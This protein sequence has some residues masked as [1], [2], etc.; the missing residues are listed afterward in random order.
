MTTHFKQEKPDKKELAQSVHVSPS[1]A[2]TIRTEATTS[3][4]ASD[5]NV[6]QP[7]MMKQSRSVHVSAVSIAS[8][9]QIT[10]LESTSAAPVKELVCE[11]TSTVKSEMSALIVGDQLMPQVEGEEMKKGEEKPEKASTT[12]HIEPSSLVI[13]SQQVVN[14]TSTSQTQV[15]VSIEREATKVAEY[16]QVV[17]ESATSPRKVAR[18]EIAPKLVH[19]LPVGEASVSEM[20]S[21]LHSHKPRS[22]RSYLSVQCSPRRVMSVEQVKPSESTSDIPVMNL[23][24]ETTEK[25]IP[26]NT[27]IQVGDQMIPVAKEIQM[28]IIGHEVQHASSIQQIDT[29]NV[30]ISR[31]QTTRIPSLP[32]S[33]IA[34]KLVHVRPVGEASVSEIATRL[35]EQKPDCKRSSRSIHYSPTR[36][37]SVERVI[38][39]ESASDT[40]ALNVA[41]ETAIP[42]L[43]ENTATQVGDLLIPESKEMQINIEEVGAE[44]TSSIHQIEPTYEAMS[45][46]QSVR[47]PSLPT[48]KVPASSVRVPVKVAESSNLTSLSVAS[49]LGDVTREI[50]PNVTHVQPLND[51]AASEQTSEFKQGELKSEKSCRSVHVS[52]SRAATVE[53]TIQ[54]ESV[55]ETRR[56]MPVLESARLSLPEKKRAA[57]KVDNLLPN[58][59]E[60]KMKQET[61]ELRKSFQ[62]IHTASKSAATIETV[63]THETP[64]TERQTEITMEHL[65]AVH[66]IEPTREHI[67]NRTS[68]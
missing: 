47:V 52:P 16:S 10:S 38:S 19:V 1:R 53:T 4:T 13:G 5:L 50:A 37:A 11:K 34:P 28:N 64:I 27:A 67:W 22:E 62:S 8:A 31:E 25:I 6:E 18:R 3:Q 57:E 41:P 40:I 54:Q 24:A 66:D 23:A 20:T 44:N 2:P 55:S 29:T 33:E 17:S 48:C 42:I 32:T 26:E 45:T 61:P 21:H 56:A 36:A 63:S 14:Q 49:P 65:H 68:F 51:A 58:E 12:F 46:E 15:L 7:R 35:Q 30:A 9:N 39:L 43:P 60:A 59:K